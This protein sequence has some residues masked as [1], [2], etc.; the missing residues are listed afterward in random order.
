M[1]LKS[2]LS[3][4]LALV[5]LLSAVPAVHAEEFAGAEIVD[6]EVIDTS[7]V[8]PLIWNSYYANAYDSLYA[9]TTCGI[10]NLHKEVKFRV[11]FADGSS[12]DISITDTVNGYNVVA[13][14]E[15]N[16]DYTAVTVTYSLAGIETSGSVTTEIIE[17]PV[18]RI[19][20]LS[21]PAPLVAGEHSAAT[22]IGDDLALVL[23][24]YDACFEGLSFRVYYK[25]GTN[26]LIH[27]EELDFGEFSEGVNP[28]Y[29]FPE[30]DGYSVEVQ[31]NYAETGF[32]YWSGN[33][34]LPNGVQQMFVHYM[35]V[36][37]LF[38]L[39]LVEG[40]VAKVLLDPMDVTAED[41]MTANLWVGITGPGMTYQ[42]QWRENESSTWKNLEWAVEPEIYLNAELRLNGSQ[43]RCVGTDRNGNV[44]ITNPATLTVTES[45]ADKLEN[46]GRYAIADLVLGADG[47]YRTP[48]NQIVYIAVNAPLNYWLGGYSLM[49]YVS[50]YGDVYFDLT[51]W[52]EL[53]A[54]MDEEGF[55]VL[56]EESLAYLVSVTTGNP[57]WGESEE[58]AALYL[59][60]DRVP[61]TPE[62][63][64]N[65]WV[66]ENGNWYFYENGVQ[67]TGWLLDG[68]VWYYLNNHMVTGWQNIGGYWYYFSANGAMQSGWLLDGG[69]WYYLN[70]RMATGWQNIGGYWYYF[71]ANGAMQSGWVLDGG[72]WYYLN[73]HMVTGWQQ[74]GGVWYYFNA[75][76]AMQS[77]WVLDG[78]VWYYLNNHMQT[79]WQ[80]IG[81]VWY[82]FNAGGA[83]QSGWQ[84]ISGNWYYL[85]NHMITGWLQ[86]GGVWYYLG[87]DGAMVTGTHVI[88]GVTYYFDASGAW[89]P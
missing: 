84:K 47:I 55:V 14:N 77:G 46:E 65:G 31:M 7:E 56:T 74:I 24:D 17:S 87:A 30:H 51:H 12:R 41:G 89:I 86:Q 8:Q 88:D 2:V 3:L 10:W 21:V 18:A 11:T 4:I 32:N 15:F 33:I 59:Y 40:P 67:K 61:T 23:D 13:H 53:V 19:E 68:G 45:T 38:N 82:Y 71:N 43:Y 79:G 1:K 54:L 16:E 76:G 37:A 60:Y 48:G 69:V 80:Q 9:A 66:Q 25:D 44:A 26:E 35:G 42:W 64:K 75:S 34:E 81:G 49:D 5:L 70:N 72:V 20:I 29:T 62:E 52:D 57:A 6:F 63:Q 58:D 22:K 85:N 50:A 36:A 28:F 39:N 78:G 83:M 27:H 73:N